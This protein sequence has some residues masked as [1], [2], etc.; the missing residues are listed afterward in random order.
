MKQHRN[1]NR[2]MGKGVFIGFVLFFISIASAFAQD[3]IT[4][5]NGTDIKALVK[6]IN[7]GTVKYKKFDNPDGP[8]YIMK[9]SEIFRIKYANGNA[10]VFSDDG[11]LI[12]TPA[13]QPN[14]KDR[15]QQ[16]Q[17]PE[18]QQ[19][20]QPAVHKQDRFEPIYTPKPNVQS[21]YQNRPSAATDYAAFT[22]LRNNDDAME[23][24]LKE[25]DDVL[26][27]QFHSGAS[28]RQ[29]GKTFLSLGLVLTGVGVGLMVA[30]VIQNNDNPD[31]GAGLALA[32]LASFS[33]GQVFTIVSIPL[34]AVGGGLKRRAANG[35]EE[36]YFNRSKTYSRTSLNLTL[37]G[38]GV[39]FAL[40]F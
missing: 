4:L 10:D 1:S 9:S 21:R 38:N 6:E 27:R 19:E 33:V 20:E 23:E 13:T 7:D 24:F 31:D 36:K 11:K 2:L 34:S 16:E 12:S 3:I 22:R 37:T 25:N 29:S 5:K 30:G 39:G 8:N 18:E 40:R 15:V 26:Y 14:A 17:Q 35:Y 32:G 28:L